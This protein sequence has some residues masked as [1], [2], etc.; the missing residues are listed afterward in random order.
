MIVALGEPEKDCI[1]LVSPTVHTP[2]RRVLLEGQQFYDFAWVYESVEQNELLD[3]NDFI[4]ND[5]ND[6]DVENNLQPPPLKQPYNFVSQSPLK[7]PPNF[8][9]PPPLNQ[10]YNFV[11]QPESKQQAIDSQDQTVGKSFNF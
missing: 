11:S 7:Q 2:S 10:P 6:S 1:A 4:W 3:L 9:S 8:I 5:L